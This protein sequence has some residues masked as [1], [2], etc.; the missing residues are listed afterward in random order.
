[1]SSSII[2][3]VVML[4]LPII[5]QIRVTST[6]NKYKTVHNSRG[7]TADQVARQ[8]LD[9]NGLYH[10][11]IERIRG[12]LTD[13]FD[14]T[15]NVIRLSDSVYGNTSVAAIGV[16]AHECGHACQHAQEYAPIKLRTAIV[17][18]TNIC[19]RLWY[20]TFLIGVLLFEAMPMIAWL[21]VIMF[22]AVVLFQLVTLPTELDASGRALNTLEAD[23]ILDYNEVP[24]ARKV[25]KAAA[26]TY[27]TALITSIMQL[28]RL[29]S[30]F[31]DN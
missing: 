17:P 31:R 20:I 18:I 21:G 6:F 9:S 19:S 5:A 1:M 8:I 13:H 4:I 22:S 16:A 28:L 14:P 26:F 27:V 7:L 15:A 11:R 29:L 30:M 24:M 23:G 10:I 12:N 2:F 25:L 3:L